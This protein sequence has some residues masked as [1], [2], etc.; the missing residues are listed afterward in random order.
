MSS[1]ESIVI[2]AR[3]TLREAFRRRL[4]WA[5]VG[6]TALIIVL[7]WW[8]FSRIAEVSPVTGPVEMLAVSQVLVML[9]FMFSFVLAMTAVFAASPA[10]GP[11][12]ESGLLLAIL[13]RPI[14][15][16]EVLLGRWLGLAVVLVGYA[17]VAGYLEVGAAGLATGY[18]PTDPAIAPLYLAGEALVLLT[19][20]MVFSTRIASVAGGAIA[21]VAYGLAW[22]AGVMGGVGEAFNSDVLR[23]AGVV[24]R[25]ILPSDVLWRGAAGALSPTEEVLRGGGVASPALYKFSP[26]S[27]SAPDPV[28][29]G[30]CLLWIVGVLAIG[31]VL[32]R[33]R[34]V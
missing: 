20:A 13:A 12:I 6:L 11:E 32:L 10:I 27:G 31:I 22:M 30:W 21:V 28:W 19:L 3:L 17:V 2:V 33:R 23:A 26:F 5:L 8:G 4:L 25:L 24:A 7:T 29:L 34:E 15:R 14:R 16:S 9:A 1:L 18:L